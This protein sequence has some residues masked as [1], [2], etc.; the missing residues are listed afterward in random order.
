LSSESAA[1]HKSLSQA[2]TEKIEEG[3][4]AIDGVQAMRYCVT[5]AEVEAAVLSGHIRVSS[6][7]LT[8][9][10]QIEQQVED[11]RPDCVSSRRSGS[12]TSSK[13]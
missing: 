12:S 11:L 3:R 7:A 9:L 2:S 4:E 5:F 8:V 6:D 13:V 1:R 10:D